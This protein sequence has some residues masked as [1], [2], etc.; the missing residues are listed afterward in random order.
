VFAKCCLLVKGAEEDSAIM[1]SAIFDRFQWSI[2]SF[3]PFWPVGVGCLS[4]QDRYTSG[5]IDE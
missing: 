5:G 3:F 4:I 2:S 1:T